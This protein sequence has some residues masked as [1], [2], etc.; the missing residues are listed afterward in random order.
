MFFTG[1]IHKIGEVHDGA[2]VT[3][4]H[5]G[6]ARSAASRSRPAAT[7]GRVARRLRSTSS[8]RPATSTSRPRSK[9]LAARPRRRRRR[10]LRGLRRRAAVRERSGRQ[11][12]R[13]KVP[14]IAFVNK[15]DRTG[16][17]FDGAVSSMAL[18]PGR[19]RGPASRS[20]SVPATSSSAIIRR[21]REEVTVLHRRDETRAPA[22]RRLAASSTGRTSSRTAT[23]RKLDAA[24]KAPPRRA[25]LAPTTTSLARYLDGEEISIDEIKALTSAARSASARSSRSC[26]RA[27]SADKGIQAPPRRGGGPPAVARRPPGPRGRRAQ[28]GQAARPQGRPQGSVLRSRVQDDRR[29]AGHAHVRARLLGHAQP[30]ATRS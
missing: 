22:S 23:R 3:D 29:R 2:A 30:A 8:T 24:R 25:R 17:D 9:R 26:A 27:A 5:A 12:N 14:R 15:M 28:D 19:E 6:G 1:R 16:A 4:L 10:L 11:A 18:A 13:Y 21:D 20:R 7:W